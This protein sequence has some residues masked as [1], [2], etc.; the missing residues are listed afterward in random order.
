[1]CS[2]LYAFIANY[3]PQQTLN[4]VIIKICFALYSKISEASRYV[5]YRASYLPK[6]VDVPAFSSPTLP[7]PLSFSLLTLLVGCLS[8]PAHVYPLARLGCS[9]YDPLLYSVEGPGPRDKP[10]IIAQSAI[11]SRTG[12]HIHH[13]FCRGIFVSRAHCRDWWSV[14][15]FEEISQPKTKAKSWG[16]WLMLMI[17]VYSY[18]ANITK[19]QHCIYIARCIHSNNS[20]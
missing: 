16:I 17:T 14:T 7:L 12:L 10:N 20:G 5:S 1:M 3:S 18:F 6:Y 15:T 19:T 4:S 2:V 11:I 8:T 13:H 9:L